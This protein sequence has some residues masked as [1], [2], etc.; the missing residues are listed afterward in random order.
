MKYTGRA[1]EGDYAAF[2]KFIRLPIN[3]NDN[4]RN[5]KLN[6][7]ESVENMDVSNTMKNRMLEELNVS[8]SKYSKIDSVDEIAEKVYEDISI[9]HD[10]AIRAEM[11]EEFL[12]EKQHMAQ[13]HDSEKH[14]LELNIQEKEKALEAQKNNSLE[15]R[16][17]NAIQRELDHKKE[18]AECITR[19]KNRIWIKSI[20]TFVVIVLAFWGLYFRNII[21][22]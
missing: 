20:V 19:N 17:E 10:E 21:S 15:N 2:C 7:R 12:V 9:K 16:V 14:K 13:Q 5:K 6:I 18:K 4:Q 3:S 11:K 8:Y 22:I 1:S